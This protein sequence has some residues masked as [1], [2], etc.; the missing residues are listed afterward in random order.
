M[1]DRPPAAVPLTFRFS[2][3]L[4][5]DGYYLVDIDGA[6]EARSF[7]AGD[8]LPPEAHTAFQ[9]SGGALN[10]GDRAF[11]RATRTRLS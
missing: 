11:A 1:T 7:K 5:M 9:P 3:P 10:I 4:D 8:A 6:T 2:V